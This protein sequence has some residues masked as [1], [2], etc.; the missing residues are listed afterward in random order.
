MSSEG[1]PQPSSLKLISLNLEI[2]YNKDTFSKYLFLF[3]YLTVLSLC[4][5]MQDLVPR[6][7]TETRPPA[8]GAFCLGHWT[9]REVPTSTL[10]LNTCTFYF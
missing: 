3:I 9:T 10:F 4:C 2:N 7:G 5:G 6:S 1:V 8:W